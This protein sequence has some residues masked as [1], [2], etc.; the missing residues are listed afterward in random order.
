MPHLFYE[1]QTVGN[2]FNKRKWNV[3]VARIKFDG[4][5][6]P[7]ATFDSITL[8]KK[9]WKLKR[10]CQVRRTTRDS[11][12]LLFDYRIKGTWLFECTT[13]A[14]SF[15]KITKEKKGKT[16]IREADEG[17]VV[18]V[19]QLFCTYRRK[20]REWG[21]TKRQGYTERQNK[22]N[23]RRR[24]KKRRKTRFIENI[25]FSSRFE[26]KCMR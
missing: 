2:R 15:V 7:S 25:W 3:F 12:V 19:K 4:N 24:R 14:F 1:D 20:K 13:L 11:F 22:S 9:F 17:F 6:Q 16:W 21:V 5:H 23:N 26:Q 18:F 10:K 8:G